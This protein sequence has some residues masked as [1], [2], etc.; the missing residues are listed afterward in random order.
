[1]KQPIS[2]NLKTIAILIPVILLIKLID[3]LPWWSFIVAVM[4]LGIITSINQWKVSGFLIGFLCGFVIWL[5]GN[6]YFH[7]TYDG[8]LLERIGTAPKIIVLL[9]SG[10]IGGL[11]TGLALYTGRSIA[12]NKKAA[13]QL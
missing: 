3:A 6:L 4:A 10:L 7:F 1:M 13:L 2:H 11:L 12:T 9:V 8:Q 5:G